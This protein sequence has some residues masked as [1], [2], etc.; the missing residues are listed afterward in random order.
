MYDMSREHKK[1]ILE[2]SLNENNHMVVTDGARGVR[3]V[4]G[5][6]QPVTPSRGRAR[7]VRR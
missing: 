4:P 3:I 5:P 2:E 6:P 7:G 1:Y